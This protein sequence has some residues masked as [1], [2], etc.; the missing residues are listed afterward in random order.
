MKEN[1]DEPGGHAEDIDTEEKSTEKKR[2]A[3]R[4]VDVVPWKSV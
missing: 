2:T 3:L 1:P 4:Y